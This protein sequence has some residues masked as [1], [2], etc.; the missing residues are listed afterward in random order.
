ML[1]QLAVLGA[2]CLML[3]PPA[4]AAVTASVDRSS[5]ELNE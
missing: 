4:V 2:A 5:I 3:A 1:R